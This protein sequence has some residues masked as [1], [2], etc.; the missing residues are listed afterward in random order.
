M[1]FVSNIWSKTGLKKEDSTG[2]SSSDAGAAAT[3]SSA[4]DDSTDE[5]QQQQQTS[6]QGSVEPETK[7]GAF[8]QSASGLIRC[9]YD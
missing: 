3:T 2:E 4:P 1:D 6:D 9:D 5:Q 7:D 8:F